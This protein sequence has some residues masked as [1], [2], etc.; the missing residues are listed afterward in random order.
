MKG[1]LVQNYFLQGFDIEN[2]STVKMYMKFVNK[3]IML[4]SGPS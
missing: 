2:A 4:V 1:M 3:K